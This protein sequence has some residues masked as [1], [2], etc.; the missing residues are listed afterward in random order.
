[1]DFMKRYMVSPRT[2]A[3]A[4]IAEVAA[5]VKGGGVVAFPTDTLYGLA[6]D[7]RRD[8]ALERLFAAK[9]RDAAAPIPLIAADLG[10][11][12]ELG[13][14]SDLALRLARAFWPGPLTIVVPASPAI[15]RRALGG[16][17]TVGIRVPAHEVALALCRAAATCVT[18]TSAN[19]SGTAP[20]ASAQEIDP[21]LAS[22]LDA[23]LDAGP[24]PGGPPSTIVSVAS[25]RPQLIRA[26][27]IAW[28][29]V[30]KSLE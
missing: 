23:V 10:Q 8:D 4:A 29:R 12:Q 2:P 28:D 13:A 11:A 25:E 9:A 27:A 20:P 22:R 3:P 30:L 16:G 6:A 24:A 7:P 14:F 15:A 18:A 5:I 1:L 26:G 19:L 21:H 17:T